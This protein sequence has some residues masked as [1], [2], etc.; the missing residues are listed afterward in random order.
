M[1]STLEAVTALKRPTQRWTHGWMLVTETDGHGVELG[2]ATASS[3]GSS[4]ERASSVT[5][6]PTLLPVASPTSPRV[7]SG[8]RGTNSRLA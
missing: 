3:S 5:A 7:V 8:P 2:C 6:M 4:V 1:T